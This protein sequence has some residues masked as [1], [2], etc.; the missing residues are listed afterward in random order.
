MLTSQAITTLATHHPDHP[1]VIVVR[2][3]LTNEVR[4]M[5]YPHEIRRDPYGVSVQIVVER[6]PPTADMRNEAL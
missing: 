6:R 3:S 5:L 1:L 2:D 4:D